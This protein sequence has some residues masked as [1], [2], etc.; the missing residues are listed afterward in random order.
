[1]IISDNNKQP[2]QPPKPTPT[3]LS[4]PHLRAILK[5][6]VIAP[7]DAAYDEARAVFYGGIDRRPAVIVRVADETDV[8]RVVSLARETGLELAVRSGGHSLAGHSTTDGGI[9]LDLSDMRTLGIDAK[10][11]TAWA[12][13]GLNTGEYTVRVGAYGLA[14]GFGDTGYV[15]IGG[16]TLGGGIG[17]LARKYGLTI[18]DLLAAE[19][20]TADG[21]LLRVDAK[22]HPDLF[23]AIR[24][25]GGNFGVVTRF[26]FRL[27]EVDTVVGGMLFLPATPDTIASFIAEAESAPEELSTIANVMTAP[28]M[29]FIPAEHHGKLINMAIMVYAGDVEEG[30]RVVARFRSIATPI[31][32]MIRPMKYPEIY[33]PEQEGYHPVAASRTMFVDRIDRAVAE[34]MLKYIQASTA[35][36]S[37]AQLRVLGGAMARVPVDATAFAHRKSRI[38]VNLAGL[39]EKSEEKVT[40]EAWV[41]DFAAA[42]KQGD[43]G[44][45]VNFMGNDG[46][47]RI[48]AAYPNGIWERLASIKARYDPTNLFHLNQNITP[49]A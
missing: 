46:E 2:Y 13:T 15:G 31:A 17:F 33:Q 27:H 40:H 39:Y 22:T 43:N 8:S 3:T 6:R 28:P 41:T 36:M 35:S 42:L 45:Y 37:V 5:G 25:G 12:Q 44:A 26:Q 18:D 34:T 21:Q 49:H 14:T 9:V 24:G 1:M 48:R 29:P 11:R 7:Y 38:M 4:I 47:T 10:R 30:Q 19:V 20:V 16:L 23:W 32:N